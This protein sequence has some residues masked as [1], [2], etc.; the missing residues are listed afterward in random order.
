MRN[1]SR[2]LW[3]A[4]LILA[5]TAL[6]AAEEPADAPAAESPAAEPAAETPTE[7]APA[8]AETDDKPAAEDGDKP[9]AEAPPETGAA[10]PKAKAYE[11]A[12][13]DWKALLT[14]LRTLREEYIAADK[15]D[16]E[17][18]RQQYNDLLSQ[19]E[20]KLTALKATAREAFA[21]APNEDRLLTRFMVKIASDALQ[22][23]DVAS[24]WET[25]EFLIENKC[26]DNRIY[27]VAG[28]A[29]Y[30]TNHFDKAQEYLET[31]AKE[32]AI[33]DEGRV[34]LAS[35]DEVQKAWAEEVKLR[36]A[37][38]KADDLPRVSL[39]TT[40]GDIVVELF[41]NEAPD[42]VG[43]FIALVEDGFYD[44]RLFHRVLPNFMAQ[45]GCP[46]GDGTGDPGYSIY[47]ECYKEPHRN[48]FAGS[49]SMAHAGRDTGGSQF[50]LTFQPT[51]HLNGKHTVFGRV[52][53]GEEVL[54]KLQRIS[55][56]APS[57]PVPDK[58]LEAKVLRKREHEYKPN[59]V[60]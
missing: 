35:L 30:A 58:I 60:K 42:T 1:F 40:K 38:A 7:T 22:R 56:D 50:Y 55:P 28:M 44:G 49:L 18:I 59:K 10:R 39:K 43:N 34:A 15:Q 4:V 57:Q 32:S 52:I 17:K 41:E 19:G 24:A 46:K 37:E 31:A 36:E 6:W 21:E 12:M 27:G 11:A 14:R 51:P 53:E 20:T 48:H 9:A 33:T 5:P 13:N 3:I 26:A 54:G 47:C 29:A 2:I 23:E 16:T 45:T 8:A 25:S